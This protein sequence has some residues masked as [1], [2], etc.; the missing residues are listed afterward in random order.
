M[1]VVLAPLPNYTL[2]QRR[3]AGRDGVLAIARDGDAFLRAPD[4]PTFY[5]LSHYLA[6]GRR[7][8]KDPAGLAYLARMVAVATPP[9]AA[10]AA[11]K[12]ADLDD[13]DERLPPAAT[14][15]LAR[16]IDDPARPAALRERT[17]RLVAEAKLTAVR[18]TVEAQ[19]AAGRALR[20]QA[21]AALASL[22]GGLDADLVETL[23]ADADPALRAVAAAHLDGDA[24]DAR[25]KQLTATDPGPG[26][27]T[28]A[29]LRLIERARLAALDTA[30]PLLGDE[31]DSVRSAVARAVAGLGEAAVDRVAAF[32]RSGE[33]R[34]AQG[35]VLSLSFDG[36]AGARALLALSEDHPDEA[37]RALATLALGKAGGHSH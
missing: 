17:L 10:E 5:S 23:L 16:A 35:A 25:L 29:A 2:W 6:L 18:E 14:E 15:W 34:A 7:G 9:L 20:P 26:V 19:S 33:R 24:V 31:D 28:V 11:D 8:R 22:D 30:L 36:G 27:R 37:V 1:L 21:L 4:A 3:F 13:L 12:L 32:A